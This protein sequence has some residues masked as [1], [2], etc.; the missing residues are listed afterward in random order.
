M[1]RFVRPETDRLDLTDGDWILVKRQLTAGEQRRA[2]ARS[3][4]P[5]RRGEQPE[6]DVETLGLGLITQY[7]LDW[8]LVDDNDRVVLIRDQPAAVVEA[9]LLA[10]DPASFA[11]IDAA[12]TA[13]VE[14][15]AAE[16]K[17][18]HG[19]TRLSAISGSAG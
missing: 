17:S 11:E 18:R 10:L 13:H 19:A 14:A 15:Q 2:Y 6:V 7:L 9:A 5:V 3:L 4:K 1:S 12:I 8:S 16:K